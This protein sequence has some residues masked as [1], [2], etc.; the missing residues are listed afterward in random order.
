[1]TIGMCIDYID[2]YLEQSKP[3]KERTRKARQSDFDSF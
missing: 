2:E 1:M 3:A